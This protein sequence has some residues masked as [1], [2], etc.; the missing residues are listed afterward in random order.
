[1]NEVF[2][3][4]EKIKVEAN[5]DV[6]ISKVVEDEVREAVAMVIDEASKKYYRNI[7]VDFSVNLK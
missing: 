1:M 5:I 6:E 2:K 7:T 4:G 3:K